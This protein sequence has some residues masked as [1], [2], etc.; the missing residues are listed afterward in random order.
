MG[1]ISE[2]AK[3]IQSLSC[4]CFTGVEAKNRMLQFI[5][6][7]FLWSDGL[8]ERPASFYQDLHMLTDTL[9]TDVLSL[10]LSLSLSQSITHTCTLSPLKHLINVCNHPPKSTTSYLTHCTHLI[11]ERCE[12]I[13]TP[14]QKPL[15]FMSTSNTCTLYVRYTTA[16]HFCLW[17]IYNI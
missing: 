10:S 5:C 7:Y 1:K 15:R 12:F 6:C 8:L 3:W 9:S 16:F 2:E 17:F 14:A 13:H 4:V 11:L